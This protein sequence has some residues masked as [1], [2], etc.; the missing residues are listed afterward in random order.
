M[1]QPPMKAANRRRPPG[2][3]EAPAASTAHDAPETSRRSSAGA[4]V[5]SPAAP[6]IA[7]PAGDPYAGA[8]MRQFNTRVLEPLHARYAQLVR[9]LAD[10]GYPTSVTEVLHALL[11]AGPTTPDQTRELV[12]AWRRK[13]EP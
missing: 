2:F 5:S 1:T 13:R 7:S 10:E 9:E 8:S 11:D 6:D 3:A 4:D 12:R